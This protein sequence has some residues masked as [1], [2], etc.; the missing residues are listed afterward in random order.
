MKAMIL[1]AGKGTR[2][3][4]LTYSMPKPMIPVLGKPIMEYIV[5]QLARHGVR[6]IMVNTSHLGY[7]IEQYFGD[8]ARFGVNMGYSFE[9][10]LDSADTLI[11]M[12]V[13]S[14]GAL[15]KIQ[16]QGGFFDDTTIVL[17]GDAIV[18]LDFAAAV[19]AHRR[20]GALA[21]VIGAEVPWE[22][23]SSYGVI[24]ADATGRVRAFQEKPERSEAVSNWASTGIYIFEPEVI[25]RVP[26]G[27]AFDIG[28]ELFP[29]LARE[30]QG[31]YC[32]KHRFNWI[33]IGKVTDYWEV[34]MKLMREPVAGVKL[35]G[36]EV[37]PGVHVGL[38]TN[39]AWD[40]I[41]ISGPVY[42]GAGA[43][44]EPGCRIVG[45]MWIGN[46]C[47]IER[48]AWVARSVLFDYTRIGSGTLFR[49]L[50]VS[51]DYCVTRDGVTQ[52]VGESVQEP[53]WGDTRKMRAAVLPS[54]ALA[55]RTAAQ[56]V[57]A[58]LSNAC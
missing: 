20:Q 54:I 33:D 7:R 27:R 31:L 19:A 8:G 28:S 55:Q 18:D 2:V 14:A 47:H 24:D 48:N 57:S 56:R 22:S 41:Q 49:D 43:T 4:P 9:G 34:M 42:I 17:C 50:I 36:R 32:Q 6:D 53:N 30:G 10:H 26:R 52:R 16:D 5:D 40:Q 3:Q 23:V 51:G 39:V 21:T 25:E 15:R 35:P 29:M 44:I 46:G 37:R 58:G 12:P 1:A 11:P 13:G 45:P 38:N